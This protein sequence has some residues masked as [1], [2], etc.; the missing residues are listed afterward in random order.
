MPAT[1]R[2]LLTGLVDYAGLFPPAAL[3]MRDVVANYA[4]YRAS[5]DA[6]M[7]GRLIVPAS[8]LSNCHSER[9][10]Q[11][12]GA[13]GSGSEESVCWP[14]SAL[15]AHLAG[16]TELTGFGNLRVDSVE[17]KAATS[18]AISDA[19]NAFGTGMTVYVEIPVSD[20]PAPLLD[21][22]AH[23]GLRAK[24][25]TGGVSP[26]AFPSTEQ[27]AR[28]IA[29]C[30]ERKVAFK[31]TAGLHHPLRASYP[32]TYADD[33]P[34]GTMFGFLNVF[35][36][37]LGARD[38]VPHDVLIALLEEGDPATIA[39]ADGAVQW[40]DTSW[41]LDAVQTARSHFAISFGSCSFREPVDDLVRLGVL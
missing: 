36:A 40:R 37:S 20:D 29:Q 16:N 22:I 10:A 24:I 4:A 15:V 28:F 26:D 35:L 9:S 25:R 38:R 7:L 13:R 18:R 30:S 32:L 39:F 17:L 19:A 11:R 34:R 3:S 21:A 31:A 5:T 2:A 14:I 23:H 6:W 12:A 8:Q 1:A 41:T 27:V 33:A